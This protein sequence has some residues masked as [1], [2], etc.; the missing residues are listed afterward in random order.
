MLFFYKAQTGLRNSYILYRLT[1]LRRSGILADSAGL[2]KLF[3][4]MKLTTLLCLFAVI[5]ATATTS[6][7]QKIS[8]QKK[9]ATLLEVLQS[10]QQQTDYFYV[11]DLEM[12]RKA[13]KISINMKRAEV[14]DV[15]TEAFKDQSLTYT[16]HDRTIVVKSKQQNQPSGQ[17]G[18]LLLDRRYSVSEPELQ[19]QIAQRFNL[20]ERIEKTDKTLRGRITD[21]KGEVL[22]G[23]NIV[24]KGTQQGTVTNVEGRYE[25]S[26][27]NDNTILVFSFVGFVSK[28]LAVGGRT[29]L[30]VSLKPDETALEEVVVIG[31]GEVNRRDLT[32]SVGSAS[33]DDMIKA[34]VP[35]FADALA[36]R[37]AGVQVSS[38]D[39]QPGTLPNIVIRG[40]N[41]LTQDNSPLYVIDGF[42][43]ENNDNGAIN[44]ADIESI[45]ILKDAS[46]TAIYGARGAN[47]VIIITTKRGKTGAPVISYNGYY[48][49]QKDIKRIKVMD[50]YEFVKLQIEK[51]SN[52]V[53]SLYLSGQGR[54]LED[55][56]N[57]KGI[58]WY[59]KVLQRAPM[60]NHNLSISGGQA[61]NKYSISGSYLGQ[62][63]IFKNTGFNRYQARI[64]LDQEINSRL[65]LGLNTNYSYTREF[66]AIATANGGSLTANLMYSIW[67]Y[68]PILTT[69][70][71]AGDI[72]YEDELSDPVHNPTTDYRTNPLL[73]LENELRERHA[74]NM[75]SNFY[76]E[77]RILDGLRLRVTGG[78][79]LNNLQI[80]AFNNSKTRTGGPGYPQSLGPNGSQTFQKVA[81][82]TNENTLT[83]SKAFN[84]IHH[85][86]VVAGY[87][88]Q[89]GRTS[90]FGATSVQISNEDLGL[91]GMDEGTPRTIQ[92]QG[93]LWSL[94][95]FLARINYDFRSK[96]LLTMSMRTDG[97]SKFESH[98]R[99]GYFPSV[100]LAYRIKDEGFLKDM[101][102]VDDAKLRVSYGATGNNRITDF[103][104]LSSIGTSNSSGYSFG[105]SVPSRGT[106]ASG[107]GNPNLK[108]ETTKQ[109]N[110]GLD[111]K[112]WHE[113][114][115]I[116]ADFYWKRTDDLLLNAQL[117]YV[118]GYNTAFKNIGSI[119]NKGIEFSV[120]TINFSRSH[121][122]WQSNFNISFNRSKVLALTENQE[123]LTS[124]TSA[125]WN[126]NPVYIA[127]I[128]QPAALLYG[129]VFDGV[130]Q[131]ADFNKLE[132][133]TYVL[134]DGIAANGG[135]RSQIQPGHA[136]Y[137]DINNDGLISL[138]DYTII[139]NPNPD[140]IGGFN[141]NFEYKGFDLNVFLQFSQGNDVINAN[142][143]PF[144]Y[145]YNV[146]NNTNQY[147]SYADRWTPENPTSNIPRVEGYGTR[148]YSSQL[149]EDASFL[150]L[151]TFSLGYSLSPKVSKSLKMKSLRVYV[152][153]QNVFTWTSYTGLDPEVS[154]RHTTLTPGF[155]YS[156]YPR[157]KTIILGLSTTF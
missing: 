53:E 75:L 54:T 50:P 16:I 18:L 74:N 85:L 5:H 34:P 38:N 138:L 67:S 125:V 127:K 8:F 49:I 15:L 86:N 92:S 94:Q 71:D 157:V 146:S 109:F 11:C 149:V 153:A 26:V 97:S 106:F 99:W 24:L 130:Y 2:R 7:A 95:S 91:E 56:R 108:W 156:P 25:I 143:I 43:I 4:T 139:G 93:S 55:Y 68:R 47:G 133:G 123:A 80:N 117:P 70:A 121:F 84:K 152:S 30:D 3:L 148:I 111:V 77:Y 19:K 9:G 51:N 150:R 33:V 14:D 115:S 154:T 81:N 96:Y 116:T 103:A 144:E 57:I 17:P 105:N 37:V 35:S 40:A 31:Y 151:K 23:V 87:T 145:G 113:R 66:G 83:W 131:Y 137:R 10:I 12:V 42:P 45:D 132:N 1:V 72:D 101:K 39:G 126:G 36:G 28:E 107:L 142:K 147:A 98:H 20:A 59:E 52:T 21:E 46:A 112:L 136:K 13:S 73:Q 90:S 104:Y 110:T 22:P 76:T 58:D 122:K 89:T 129:V 78:I 41:S 120:N 119:S 82:L 6:E 140:F 134:K 48:G 88:Q 114:L 65:K 63:G 141:N 100:G 29:E 102:F 62:D 155:D 118:T 64:T 27:P 135:T 128:G 79:G 69:S 61:K 32:G 124:T 60:Q 44:P